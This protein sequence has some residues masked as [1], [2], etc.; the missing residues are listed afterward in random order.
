[1]IG[2]SNNLKALLDGGGNDCFWGCRGIFHIVTADTAMNVEIGT[3][4]AGSTR[5]ICNVSD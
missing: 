1:M 4:E 3:N 2:Q 5:Q